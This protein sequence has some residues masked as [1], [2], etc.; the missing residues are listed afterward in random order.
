MGLLSTIRE[1]AAVASG[2]FALMFK[3]VEIPPLPAAISSLI[4]EIN[5]PEPD[6]GRLELIISAEPE[7]AVKVIRTI[8]SAYY[9][10]KTEVLS[11]RHA[12]T[13]LGLKNIQTLVLSYAMQKALPRPQGE[14]FKHEAYWTD[15]LLRALLARSLAR[16]CQPGQEENAFTAMLLADVA[17]PVLLCSWQKYYESVLARW[18]DQPE[19]L[20]AIE[21]AD[22]GWDHAGASAWILHYWE[23]P[24]L[25]TYLVGTHTLSPD[26]IRE[27]GLENTVAPLIVAAALLPSVLKPDP[28]RCRQLVSMAIT[29]LSL[30][31]PEG[32][33]IEAEIERDFRAICAQFDLSAEG[34]VST[35]RTLTPA[36]PEGAVAP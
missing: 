32:P 13:L 28:E 26:Q 24:E 12:I 9:G 1:H 21:Q 34:A 27:L 30:P 2:N 23:F 10:L 19:R 5:K 14:L 4:N 6:I 8:N 16:R 20:S 29:E 31:A 11:I 17:L 35:L 18:R 3:D 7:I 36:W 33:Q 25:I 22:F 15:T